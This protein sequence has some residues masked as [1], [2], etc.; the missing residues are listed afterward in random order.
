MPAETQPVAVLTLPAAAALALLRS[1]EL[2]QYGWQIRAS[3]ARALQAGLR[4]NP[5]VS[6]RVEDVLGTGRFEGGREAQATLELAQAIELGGKRAARVAATTA[7]AGLATQ[8]YE[9]KRVD[10]TAEVARRFIRVLAAQEI[11]A[12]TDITVRLTKQS[13]S[14]VARRVEAGAESPL[15]RAKARVEWARSRIAGEHAHHEL[16]AARREL[17]ATWADDQPRFERVDGPL[18][19]RAT[20]PEYTELATRLADAPTIA[21]QLSERRLREAE[22]RLAETRR[23]PNLTVSGGV[24]RLEGPGDEAFLFSVSLPLPFNDRGQG[25][26]SEAHA[27]LA[28]SDAAGQATSVRLRTLVFTVH[29]ELQHAALAL[30]TLDREI[31]PESKSSLALARSGFDEGRF[32]YLELLDAQRTLVAVERERITTAETYHQLVLELERLLGGP[33]HQDADLNTAEESR[34]RRP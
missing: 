12:L 1:P 29:Q 26:V 6:F 3:E 28:K 14:A 10:V 5:E 22:L 17:A 2:A 9:V 20:V 24:R 4:P 16:A 23:I 31:V 30:D 18:F 27:L 7:A 21:R 19:R 25:G 34:R 8:E 33:L 13:V 11:V 32:S 15:A